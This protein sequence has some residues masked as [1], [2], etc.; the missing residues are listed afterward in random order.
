MSLKPTSLL[1]LLIASMASWLERQAASQIDYLKAD[2]RALR[3]RL[4]RRRI[5]FSDAER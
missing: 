1:A 3:S 5:L 2:N 4:D